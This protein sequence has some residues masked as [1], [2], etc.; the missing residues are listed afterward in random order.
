M[1]ELD[2]DTLNSSMGN[3]AGV[4]DGGNASVRQPGISPDKVNSIIDKVRNIQTGLEFD[5]LAEWL[6]KF[7]KKD[8]DEW[9][10]VKNTAE[11]I[12]A[13]HRDGP[14]DFITCNFRKRDASFYEPTPEEDFTPKP[15][16]V[17]EDLLF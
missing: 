10:A 6:S 9:E 14:T 13:K 17:Q 2:I 3:W 12:V 5:K 16:V 7:E 11:I 1:E 15:D 8:S 4:D